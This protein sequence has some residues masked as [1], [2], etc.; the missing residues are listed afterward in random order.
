[1]P[2]DAGPHLLTV[3]PG[4][5]PPQTTL[6]PVPSPHGSPRS[7]LVPSHTVPSTILSGSLAGRRPPPPS[8]PG[9]RPVTIHVLPARP[10]LPPPVPVNRR[11]AHVHPS[12][13]PPFH[14]SI[15][16]SADLA[17]PL[18]A[19]RRHSPPS[20]SPPSP[21]PIASLPALDIIASRSAHGPLQQPRSALH[22]TEHEST[23]TQTVTVLA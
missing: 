3:A 7:L 9:P 8:P 22:A 18:P 2:L 20:P 1:M 6:N 10:P 11:P 13:H 19:L 15:H 21:A 12:I 5:G 14:P 4:A 16:R 17:C 23:T